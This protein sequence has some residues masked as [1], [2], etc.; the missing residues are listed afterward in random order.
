MNPICYSACQ[1]LISSI[2]ITCTIVRLSKGHLG[3]GLRPLIPIALFLLVVTLFVPTHG[4]NAKARRARP[5]YAG[6]M[7][8]IV[9]FT[10]G[11][12]IVTGIQ[13]HSLIN[14][15]NILTAEKLDKPAKGA[16]DVDL[17]YNAYRKVGSL[18]CLSIHS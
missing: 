7:I 13:L 1:F 9:A 16:K 3:I 4:T 6:W 8:T 17:Y 12:M 10:F 18:R 11:M 2:Q 15:E 14:T 5:H